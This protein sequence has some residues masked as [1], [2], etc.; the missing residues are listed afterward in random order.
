MIAHLQDGFDL[1]PRVTVPF[2]GP[3]EV[4]SVTP[5]DFYVTGP[6]GFRTP[7]IQLVWDPA[8]NVLAGEPSAFLLEATP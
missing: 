4:A 1:R 8:T 2:S 7:V 6:K 3:I 5:A